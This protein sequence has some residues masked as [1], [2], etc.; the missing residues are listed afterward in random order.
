MYETRVPGVGRK[1][2]LDRGTDRL[3]VL[4]RHDGERELYRREGDAD[5][6]KLFD[7]DGATARRLGAILEG[8]YFQPVEL[9]EVALPLGD[10]IIEWVDVSEDSPLAG[11]TLGDAGVWSDTGA[12]VLAV[13]RGRET[14]TTPNPDFAVEAGDV[15]VAVGTRAEQNALEDI[16]ER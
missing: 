7:L 13:Q 4:V 3:V 8:A 12:T 16:A 1:Y 14:H 15:L 6:E 11:A 10:A 2:E 5:A 9:D